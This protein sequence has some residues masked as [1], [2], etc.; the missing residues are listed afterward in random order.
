MAKGRVPSLAS[1][2]RLDM[3][4][5]A[6]CLSGRTWLS[7]SSMN[8]R[9][10]CSFTLQLRFSRVCA[11]ASKYLL[12]VIVN[13]LGPPADYI[14]TSVDLIGGLEMIRKRAV[15]QFYTNQY[16]FDWDV[17]YLISRANDGHLTVGLC[18]LEVFHFEHGVPLVSVSEDGLQIPEIYTFCKFC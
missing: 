18:A 11:R 5:F 13:M 9:D 3:T 16:D 14:S 1:L 12:H 2:A 4:V 7:T 10:I 6:P 8:T 17:N 15:D